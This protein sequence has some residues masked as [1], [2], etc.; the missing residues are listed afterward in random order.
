MFSKFSRAGAQRQMI[1]MMTISSSLR[2][3]KVSGYWHDTPTYEFIVYHA[4]KRCR[5][6]QTLEH[7]LAGDEHESITIVFLDPQ[8]LW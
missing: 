8:V 1:W 7:P 3:S 4:F 2:A 6:A 5:L